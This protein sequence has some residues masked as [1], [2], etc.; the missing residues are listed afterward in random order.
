MLCEMIILLRDADHGDLSKNRK[1]GDVIII[2]TEAQIQTKY[3]EI[4]NKGLLTQEILDA[5]TD[6]K[7]ILKN[8]TLSDLQKASLRWPWGGEERKMFLIARLDL[9]AQEITDMG[10]VD[11]YLDPIGDGYQFI[12]TAWRKKHFDFDSITA[13]M[14]KD[15]LLD[16]EIDYQPVEKEMTSKSHIIIRD[17]A[18]T[19]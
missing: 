2:K 14:D 12:Q 11:G 10:S 18:I 17:P 13:L 15:S 9:I 4:F 1:A 7:K 8:V 16:M 6:I 5:Y 19:P 3:A